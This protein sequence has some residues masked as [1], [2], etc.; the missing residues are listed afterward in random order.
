M[1]VAVTTRLAD[2]EATIER[3][4]ATFI[5]VGQAL[6]EINEKK[7]YRQQGYTTFPKYCKGRWQMSSY[8]AYDHI[9]TAKV[10]ANLKAAG[11]N[12]VPR[13][14]SQGRELGALH[15][16]SQKAIADKVDF[17]TATANDVRDAVQDHK[18][19]PVL[20]AGRSA[21]DIELE[22][23]LEP[24][25]P[26]RRM[27]VRSAVSC[28]ILGQKQLGSIECLDGL[29]LLANYPDIRHGVQDALWDADFHGQAGTV[30][31]L[32]KQAGCKLV[33]ESWLSPDR[34]GPGNTILADYE[35]KLRDFWYATQKARLAVAYDVTTSN[36][37]NTLQKCL[38]ATISQLESLN[39]AGQAS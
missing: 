4:K 20:E 7:L 34:D 28:T 2:L 32:I 39:K 19:P 15:P 5:E 35:T 24:L 22:R 16:A 14:I 29:R 27:A 6:L 37:L 38:A 21:L 30:D 36:V 26:H 3:G 18:R 9:N 33:G 11:T 1:N 8:A 12:N 23:V 17:A 31:R 25:A 10:T 13:N